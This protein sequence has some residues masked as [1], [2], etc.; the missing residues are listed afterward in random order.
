MA[1]KDGFLRERD[2][3]IRSSEL[4]TVFNKKNHP[5]P[6]LYQTSPRKDI[7]MDGFEKLSS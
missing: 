3:F 4:K 7:F 2:L 5:A 6:T 1:P